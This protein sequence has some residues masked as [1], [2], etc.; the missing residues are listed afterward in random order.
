MASEKDLIFEIGTEEIPAGF[1]P[2]ALS[3][4][5]ERIVEK[6]EMWRLSHGE[7]HTYGTPR[8]LA[9]IVEGLV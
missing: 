6:L 9:L 2:V 3:A 7:V 4:M 1:I 8:R 5:K